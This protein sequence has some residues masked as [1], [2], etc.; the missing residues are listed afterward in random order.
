MKLAINRI[1]KS[2]VQGFI[3]I[4]L[5]LALLVPAGVGY[6]KC[7][8]YSGRLKIEL[9]HRGNSRKQ[10]DYRFH[11]FQTNRL[12]QTRNISTFHN[13]SYC[14]SRSENSKYFKQKTLFL[15]I[16][17]KT[18]K[19]FLTGLISTTDDYFKIMG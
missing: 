4:I 15:T 12:N 17:D 2:W 7:N 14:Y 3:K 16:K 10:T 11:Y 5:V 13:Q 9:V 19:L 8:D 18:V 1:S 6:T